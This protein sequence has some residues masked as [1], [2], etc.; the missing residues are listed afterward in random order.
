MDFD[1]IPK[2]QNQ[3]LFV[4]NSKIC[5]YRPGMIACISEEN[6]KDFVQ[7]YKAIDSYANGRTSSEYGLPP[8]DLEVFLAFCNGQWHRAIMAKR[9]GDGAPLCVL[10]DVNSQQKIKVKDI[11]PM[12]AV[13]ASPPLMTEICQIE[14]FEDGQEAQEIVEKL[15]NS[16]I[17]ADE[18]KYVQEMCKI[19]VQSL[20]KSAQS[21][22][23]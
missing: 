9:S 1:L 21:L 10:I 8:E 19:T 18:I 16:W 14:G 13:F 3:R 15:E 7:M 4:V 2:G 20:S 11:I 22:G 23:E 17:V 12:P 6:Y 5:R